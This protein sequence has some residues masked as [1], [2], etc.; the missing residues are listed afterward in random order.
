M[1]KICYVI[2]LLESKGV[3]QT[4]KHNKHLNVCSQK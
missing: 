2:L 1:S 4:S 3:E